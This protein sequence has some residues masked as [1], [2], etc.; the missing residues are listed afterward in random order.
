MP[1]RPQIIP[2]EAYPQLVTKSE[3][4]DTAR[5]LRSPAA[6]RRGAKVIEQQRESLSAAVHDL[7]DDLENAGG[8]HDLVLQAAHEI[9]G[10]GESAGLAAAGRIA[11]GLCHYVDEMQRCA[12]RPDPNIV[13]LHVNAILRATRNERE[14]GAISEAV[15]RELAALVAHRLTDIK[16]LPETS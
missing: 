9:R 14:R 2:P 10:L 16:K 13:D 12:L 8:A 4:A 5:V 7:A 15:A 6:A 1:K 3:A 11:D